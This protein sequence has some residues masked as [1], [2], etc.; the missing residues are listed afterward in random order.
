VQQFAGTVE[1]FFIKN[2]ENVQGDERDIILVSTVYGPGKDGNVRQNFGLMSREVGWRRLNVLVTRAKLSTRVFTSL[3]P[4]DIKVTDT[5]SKGPRAF[6]DYL[7]YALGAAEADND[8]GGIPD[9]D[10]EVFVA[11]RLEAAGYEVIPQVGVDQ[12]RIDLGVHAGMAAA[13]SPA[14]NAMVP[15]STPT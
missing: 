14:S 10:F 6:R 1:E 15:R 4:E 2:L 12:F 11:E 13:S 8:A 7:T 9:S 3:R 5:S